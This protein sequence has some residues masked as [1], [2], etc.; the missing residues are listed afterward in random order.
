M[1]KVIER[2]AFCLYL[3]GVVLYFLRYNNNSMDTGLPGYLVALQFQLFGSAD[4]RMT[5]LAAGRL[6]RGITVVKCNDISD[7]LVWR[8]LPSPAQCA[9]VPFL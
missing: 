9:V 4:E 2:V 6:S 5:A 1:F 7:R 3:V 8:P